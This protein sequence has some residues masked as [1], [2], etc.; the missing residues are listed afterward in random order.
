MLEFI[1]VTCKTYLQIN[2]LKGFHINFLE[3][4]YALKLIRHVKYQFNHI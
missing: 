3:T 4:F 2:C 1:A